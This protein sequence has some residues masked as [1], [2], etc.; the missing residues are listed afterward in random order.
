MFQ[1]GLTGGIG[2]GK[3]LVCKVLEKLGVGVYYADEEA[4]KLMNVDSG[5]RKQIEGLFGKEAYQD[6]ELNRELL[7]RKVFGDPALLAKLN[8]LVHPVVRQHYSGWVDLQANVP[9]LV[10]EAAILFESGS[11]RYMDLTVL[12]YADEEERIQ[13]VM[14]RDGADREE[15]L[16]RMKTQLS[17]EKKKE[18]TDY[19]IYNDGK[20]M[21]L[22]Q[23]IKLHNS[24]L[25][26]G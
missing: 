12:V 3:T 4:R 8:A 26:R 13:R 2:S 21:L 23:I 7:A 5:L 11:D 10:E 17:E 20:E 14:R 18:L 1:V 19:I 22:P 9:Y 16:R 24:I 25:K 6:G 15:V